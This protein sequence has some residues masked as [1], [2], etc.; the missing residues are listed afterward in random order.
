MQETKRV[1]KTGLAR[2]TRQV[3]NDVLR[4]QVVVVES[5]GEPTVVI[6]DIID[7]RITRTVMR[8]YSQQ[9][10][11]DA[12][13]GVSDEQV[14]KILGEQERFDL[15]LA[16]YLG[17]GISLERVAELLGLSWLDLRTRFLRLDVPIHT[18]PSDVPKVKSHFEPDVESD[19]EEAGAWEMPESSRTWPF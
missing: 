5:H 15:V 14:S 13:A 12:G 8:Y 3:L 10:P 6:M 18:V 2:H 4:G 16:H 9:P 7:Y 11:I 1:S 19:V 17:G